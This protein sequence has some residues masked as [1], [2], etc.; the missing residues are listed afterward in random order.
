MAVVTLQKERGT[1][2]PLRE[3]NV[4]SDRTHEGISKGFH[5][6]EFVRVA[7]KYWEQR[8][9]QCSIMPNSF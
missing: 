5:P 4:E 6:A 2:E 8:P 7:P 1:D 9:C 3:R